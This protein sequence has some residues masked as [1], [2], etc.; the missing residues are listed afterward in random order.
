M[1]STRA[2]GRPDEHSLCQSTLRQAREM[3][4]TPAVMGRRSTGKCHSGHTHVTDE[5]C[6]LFQSSRETVLGGFTFLR[7]F[8]CFVKLRLMYIQENASLLVY[9]LSVCM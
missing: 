2:S 8:V 5:A 3:Q 1:A 7:F 6:H 4:V 9:S